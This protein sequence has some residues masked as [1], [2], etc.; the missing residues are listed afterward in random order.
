MIMTSVTKTI[1][2]FIRDENGA[3]AIEYGLLASLIAVVIIA[4]AKAIGINLGGVFTYVSTQ[5]T[6]P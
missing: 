5:L 1:R 6:H 4:G 2:A 3:A